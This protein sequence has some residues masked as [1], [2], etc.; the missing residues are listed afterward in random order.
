[1]AATGGGKIK[2]RR[3]HIAAKPYA[4]SKQVNEAAAFALAVQIE[5]VTLGA[6]PPTLPPCYCFVG[7]IF[8]ACR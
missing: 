6:L 4:K 1:M 3:Y 8:M 2:G 7:D 5:E